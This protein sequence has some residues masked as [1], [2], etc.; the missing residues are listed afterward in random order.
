MKFPMIKMR[1]IVF[2]GLLLFYSF[3]IVNHLF[4]SYK[5]GATDMQSASPGADASNNTTPVTDAS[6]AMV[7]TQDMSGDVL[8]LKKKEEKMKHD[9]E[10]LRKQ[11][12]KLET[13]SSA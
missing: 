11:I 12:H 4:L 6:N 5:E 8:S 10:E 9:L 3:F 1:T 7:V 13:P 2:W